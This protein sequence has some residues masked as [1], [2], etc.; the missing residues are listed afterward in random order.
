MSCEI[1]KAWVGNMDNT[2]Y[3][4]RDHKV[5]CNADR[6]CPGVAPILEE[7]KIQHYD[8]VI[9]LSQA[10]VPRFRATPS[11]HH[12][13]C[14]S[15][16]F[17]HLICQKCGLNVSQPAPTVVGIGG[18]GAGAAMPAAKVHVFNPKYPNGHCV[19]C[20]N[21]AAAI[22]NSGRSTGCI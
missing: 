14:I 16:S 13:L 7:V 19:I 21:S 10:I 4:C 2:Y 15:N 1:V 20:G 8:P 9:E 18:S 22:H 17:G 5:E 12:I 11:C 3:Y 6:S